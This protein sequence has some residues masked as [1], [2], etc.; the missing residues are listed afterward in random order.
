MT[1]DES[2]RLAVSGAV[3]GLCPI[4]EANLG[5]GLF[6]APEFLES[7]G[8]FGVGTD[9]NVQI[10]FSHELRMLEYGQRLF[11][12]SRNVLATPAHST[13][14]AL[15][16]GAQR[17]GAMAVGG[18][19]AGLRVGADADIVTLRADPIKRQE[20]ECLDGWIF[21]ETAHVDCVYVR[22][23]RVVCDGAHF[24][25]DAIR[26]GFRARMRQLLAK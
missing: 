1:G 16:E 24:A 8:H 15:F 20:D 21:A 6:D 11:R 2:R 9:S 26:D 14:R 3:A 18:A 19:P 25:R 7:G 10:S 23:R 12:R 13:G 4:T 5:D 22:G 17:G